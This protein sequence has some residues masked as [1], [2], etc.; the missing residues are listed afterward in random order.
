MAKPYIKKATPEIIEYNIR[1]F[2]TNR[3]IAKGLGVSEALI[4]SRIRDMNMPKRVGFCSK[5]RSTP[6]VLKKALELA[7]TDISTTDLYKQVSDI[8]NQHQENVEKKLSSMKYSKDAK[9]KQYQSYI[10]NLADKKDLSRVEK[11]TLMRA[12]G[13]MTLQE[14][15]DKFN[16]T[17]ERVRQIEESELSKYL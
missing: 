14:I 10:S 4:A 17:R 6:S 12:S 7:E 9:K 13:G 3:E 11:I 1:R 8:Y 15:G 2:K 16:L 5:V